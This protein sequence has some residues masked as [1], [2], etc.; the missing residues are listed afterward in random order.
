VSEIA[1]KDTATETKTAPPEIGDV[2][3]TGHKHE[4][5]IYAGISLT[6]GKTFYVASKDSGV[7]KWKEAMEFAARESARVPSSDELIQLYR[8]KNIGALKDTFD[9]SGSYPDEWYWSATEH[10]DH[11]YYA[12]VQRFDI[13]YRDW[14]H[15][16]DQSSLRLVRS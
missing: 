8:A 13:G 5:W 10:R 3:P 1:L 16:D 4:G 2:M 7:F 12:W 9:V 6:T 15:K 11:A 14:H